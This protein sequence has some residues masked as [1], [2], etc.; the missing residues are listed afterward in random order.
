MPR[1]IIDTESS[2]P[3]YIRRNATIVALLILV[4]AVLVYA[5]VLHRQASPAGDNPYGTVTTKSVQPPA[6]Q[7]KPPGK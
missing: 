6:P 2:R 7:A 3:A 1:Q 4:V 5:F